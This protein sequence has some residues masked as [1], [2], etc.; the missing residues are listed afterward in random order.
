MNR[1]IFP[2]VLV[3]LAIGLFVFYT[4]GA[5]QKT[6]GLN[7]ELDHY[8]TAL[9]QSEQILE[10]RDQMLAKRNNLPQD[11][12][13]RLQQL[14]PDNIDNIRLII[15]INDIA[16][17]YHMLVESISIGGQAQNTAGSSNL[18]ASTE[19]GTS[20]GPGPGA[21][22]SVTLGFTVDATYENF[23]IFLR[24]LEKSLRLVDATA[25]DFKSSEKALDTY[26]LII[27]TYWLK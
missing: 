26:S 6:K 11:G 21:V 23:N 18:S 3:I 13:S 27:T 1:A 4:N 17:R 8:T 24:D 16:A 25:I 20:V 15:N 7:A 10:L 9:I 12:V 5:Y 22:G 19:V 14:L 2:F